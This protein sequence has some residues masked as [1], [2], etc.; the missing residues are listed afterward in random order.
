VSQPTPLIRNNRDLPRECSRQNRTSRSGSTQHRANREYSSPRPQCSDLTE[1]MQFWETIKGADGI[2]RHFHWQ[3]RVEGTLNTSMTVTQYLGTGSTSRGR[4]TITRQ[5]NTL[6]STPPYLRT[7]NDKAAVVQSLINL[8][9]VLEPVAN[10]TW[11]TPKANV[12]AEQ[13]IASVPAIPARRGSN[14]WTGKHHPAFFTGSR[15]NSNCRNRQ[16]R[17]RR[18]PRQRNGGC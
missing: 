1:V 18:R 4:L 14:H 3:S 16:D 15:T 5:L 7:D 2:N 9:K 10:L 17:I 12:T 6:V 13:F 11:I 8:Q